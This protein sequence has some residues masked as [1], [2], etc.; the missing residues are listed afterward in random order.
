MSEL[1]KVK[2]YILENRM[3]ENKDSVIVG[4]SGGADSVCLLDIL[5]RLKEEFRIKIIA[6]HI[7]HGIRGQEADR[8]LEF[9]KKLCEDRNVEFR[10]YYYNVPE[11]AKQKRLTEEEAGRQLRYAT[12]YDVSKTAK[13]AIAHNLND[14]VETFIHN[15]CRG[16]GITGLS[17]IRNVNDRIIRPL[18]CLTRQEIE[19]YLEK[20]N[21]RYITDSSNFNEEYTRNKI[22]LNVIPYLCENINN[23]TCEHIN[24][25]SKDLEEAEEYIM[26]NCRKIYKEIFAKKNDEIFVSRTDLKREETFIQKRLIRMAI[27]EIAGRLKDISRKHVEDVL[28]LTDKQSGKYLM[29]P[30]NI[31]VRLQHNF[32][33]FTQE[34][35]TVDEVDRIAEITKSGTY[36]FGNYMFEVEIFEVDKSKENIKNLE[37]MV[38][39]DGK[40][41]TKWFDYDKINF[42]ACLRNRKQGDY[43]VINNRGGRK[44]IKQYFVDEK[45]PVN[46]RQNIPLLADG[47]HIMWVFGYRISEYYKI[48]KDTKKVIK[49]TGKDK[50]FN[51]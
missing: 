37:N 1:S 32:L 47:D 21:I 29:L 42:T 13:I 2:Q 8:D 3:I 25:V 12:F 9:A 27:E 20:N 41:Y 30:Y 35:N 28:K 43:L 48:T 22:R 17:G 40:L 49:I 16:T 39:N 46:S 34:I 4:L 11:Y 44:K 18:L 15:I 51:E 5:V 50:N 6:V 24:E 10:E 33:V 19:A 45:I 26:A 36:K 31:I 38:K 23:R 7:H 14:N